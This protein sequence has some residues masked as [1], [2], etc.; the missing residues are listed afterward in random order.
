[1]VDCAPYVRIFAC[2]Y[3]AMGVYLQDIKLILLQWAQEVVESFGIKVAIF[4]QFMEIAFLSTTGITQ[5]YK[6]HFMREKIPAYWIP[7][8]LSESN[9]C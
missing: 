7:W 2:R 8:F 9:F 5:N 6:L 1:M 3:S 4:T